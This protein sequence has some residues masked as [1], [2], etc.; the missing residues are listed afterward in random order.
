M[1]NK[2]PET[3]EA[4]NPLA[5]VD[6]LLA[7]VRKERQAHVERWGVQTHP[8]YHGESQRRRYEGLANYYKEIWE[9]QSALGTITWDV[10]L[11]EEAYEALSEPDPEK[12]C[13][14]LVQ[15]AAV[16]LAEAEAIRL[17]H[18]VLT[19]EEPQAEPEVEVDEVTA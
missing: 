11:L 14:E 15:V 13:Y 3:T 18:G 7:E 2:K 8:S 9:A 10:V 17:R 16:A 12:R 19:D 6:E 5:A 1:T 4:P